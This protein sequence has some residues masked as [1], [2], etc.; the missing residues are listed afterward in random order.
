MHNFVHTD[1]ILDLSQCLVGIDDLVNN[2][3]EYAQLGKGKTIG[4]FFF[5]PSLRTRLST[6]KAAQELG[7]NTLIMNFSNDGWQLEF[8]DGSIMNGSTAEH[9]KEA[10]QVMSIYCDIIAIRA[11]PKLKDKVEDYAE[12]VL[13]SFISY[14]SVPVVNLESATA[15]PLQALADF[16]TIEQ[17]KTKKNPKVV[18]TWAPHPKALPQA[19]SNSFISLL[20][21]AKVELVV[22][23]PEGY[24][25]DSDVVEGVKVSYDQLDAFKE[26]D[27][28]YVKNWS[29]VED[30][31]QVL[32]VDVDWMVDG[33]K[34]A[35][36][37]K[38]KLMHCLP[39]RRNVVISDSVLDSDQSAV[40]DQVKNRVLSAKWVLKKMLS[41][42]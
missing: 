19:V 27:F 23:H 40:M 5:N 20:K 33:V 35:L 22:T 24:D 4:M 36:T 42:G 17:L 39:V 12:Q 1:D 26:A 9:I 16:I 2:P 10:A 32:P 14:A 41:H 25:L 3:E 6:Q 13:N 7:L 15:H 31:G 34:M 8:E 37:N 28:I 11:F 18:L 30:Y 21:R 29:S 38:A